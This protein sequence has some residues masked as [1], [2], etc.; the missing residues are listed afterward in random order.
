MSRVVVNRI[1]PN[2]IHKVWR[3]LLYGIQQAAPVTNSR[4]DEAYNNVLAM[5]LSERAQ[6]FVAYHPTQLG[7]A[8]NVLGFIITL[9]QTDTMSHDRYLFAYTIYSFQGLSDEV[10]D[11]LQDAVENFARQNNCIRLVGFT[12]NQR[13]LQQCLQR[14][15][16]QDIT[17]MYKE[18]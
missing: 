11:A 14:G 18:L 7:E 1:Q 10:W 13:V 4:T 16:K 6:C 3:R 15:A 9:I 5:L 12:S 17:F 8:P 2:A